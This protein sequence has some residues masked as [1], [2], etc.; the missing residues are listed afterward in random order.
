MPEKY[1]FYVDMNVAHTQV[2]LHHEPARNGPPALSSKA[3]LLIR[4]FS[5]KACQDPRDKIYG[6]CGLIEHSGYAG[7]NVDYYLS[8]ASVYQETVKAM[9]RDGGGDL[10]C[11]TGSGFN[12][13]GNDLPSWV[14]NFEDRPDLEKVTY[15]V[16]RFHSYK[17]YNASYSLTEASTIQVDSSLVL[18]GRRVDEISR[19][20]SAI[21]SRSWR[22]IH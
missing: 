18:R 7:L 6:I 8:T 12:S 17:L 15:D 4:S 13:R 10:Q 22:H 14:R 20:G 21:I 2:E 19:V 3:D 11:L 5:Y 16:S 9:L 1:T